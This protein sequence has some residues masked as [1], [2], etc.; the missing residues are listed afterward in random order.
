VNGRIVQRLRTNN[1]GKSN[2]SRNEQ[3]SEESVIFH[4]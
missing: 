4:G 3:A 1:A 2:Y